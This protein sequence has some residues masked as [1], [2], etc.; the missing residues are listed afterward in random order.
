MMLVVRHRVLIRRSC[1]KGRVYDCLG[2]VILKL[3]WKFVLA[4]GGGWCLVGWF[5][6]Q[7]KIGEPLG[8]GLGL[9]RA[10]VMGLIDW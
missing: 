9:A 2:L 7:R 4:E 3:D 6:R 8:S 5:R 1:K 10:Q